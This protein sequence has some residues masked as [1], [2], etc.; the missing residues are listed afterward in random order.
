MPND[1]KFL[2]E[3]DNLCWNVERFSSISLRRDFEMRIY[4]CFFFVR[5][6]HKNRNYNLYW[7]IFIKKPSIMCLF[8]IYNVHRIQGDEHFSKYCKWM[9]LF[10]SIIRHQWFTTHPE[11]YVTMIKIKYSIQDTRILPESESFSASSCTPSFSWTTN[12]SSVSSVFLKAFFS[13]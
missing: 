4:F 3:V 8:S 5:H 7:H 11:S 2:K 1:S 6:A 12:S 10:Q 13:S 9:L